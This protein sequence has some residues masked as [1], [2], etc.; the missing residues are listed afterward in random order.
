MNSLSPIRPA[1]TEAEESVSHP[2]A[3][4]DGLKVAGAFRRIRSDLA[5]MAVAA[6]IAVFAFLSPDKIRVDDGLGWD[7]RLYGSW[8][9][10]FRDFVIVDK[11]DAYYV[12][13]ILPAVVVHFALRLRGIPLS[14]QNVVRAFGVLNATLICLGSYVWLR[15]AKHLNLTE[16][17]KTLGFIGLFLNYAVVKWPSYCPVLNDTAAWFG[18]LLLVLL[19]LTERRWMLALALPFLAFTWPAL[20]AEGV[21][22]L[23]LPA[24]ACAGKA[25]RVPS[26]PWHALLAGFTAAVMTMGIL[27]GLGQGNAFVPP[28]AYLSATIFGVYLFIALGQLWRWDQL[29]DPDFWI[30]KFRVTIPF[31]LLAFIAVKF[32]VRMETGRPARYTVSTFL[33]QISE[34]G[35]RYPGGFLVAHIVF[36]G[37]LLLVAF[38]RWSDIC[39][40]IRKLGVG[41][42]AAI[43]FALV[44]SLDSESR[45]LIN[46]LPLLVVPIACVVNCNPWPWG[47]VV[48]FGLLSLAFAKPWLNIGD[49]LELHFLSQGPYMTVPDYGYQ[50][51]ALVLLSGITYWI[52]RHYGGMPPS[53]LLPAAKRESLANTATKVTKKRLRQDNRN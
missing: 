22:L 10:H 35:T 21:L 14:D 20:L 28:I 25:Q 43:S 34:T 46:F 26:I 5:L 48:L 18:G 9:Q 17:A 50:L 31:A 13:K 32:L 41:L 7:G 2:Q 3:V 47:Y 6:L 42:T 27:V 39:I 11:P 30:R 1:R 4:K 24:S 53:E 33:L 52:L 23:A 36:F 51:L 12:S 40:A 29:F 16:Q 44:L 19:Y 38:F 45:H 49:R 37:P 8:V 15:I